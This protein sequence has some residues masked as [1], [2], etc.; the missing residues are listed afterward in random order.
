MR[1]A[2]PALA[3][4]A[5]AVGLALG[6]C[7]L[8]ARLFVAAAPAPA[9]PPPP[10][11]ALRGLPELRSLA[12]LR[13]PGVR[14]VYRGRL[15][16]TNRFGLRGPEISPRPAPG[17]WRIAIVGDSFTL[18]AQVAEKE[19]YAARLE[20]L[21]DAPGAPVEVLNLGLD[22]LD[23]EQIPGR[24]ARVGLPLAP[25]LVVYGFTL[26]DIESPRDPPPP[27]RADAPDPLRFHDSPLY[28][29]RLLGPRLAA[30]AGG[31]YRGYLVGMYEDPEKFARIEAGLDALARLGRSRGVC[32]HVLVHCAVADLFLWH[33]FTEAYQKVEEAARARGMTVTQALPW[34]R[35]K[36][37][38][39]LRVSPLDGHPNAE[40]HRLLA[41]ALA[42]GLRALP[43]RCQRERRAG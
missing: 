21:L 24:L 7:E 25:D 40:G 12:D 15:Y 4:A 17:T 9:P 31:A 11:P 28:L 10:D 27:R 32:V 16:R 43:P 20:A 39:R 35:W 33:P 23:I 34:F 22:G 37:A 2:L 38:A 19:T 41:E 3:L 18:G 29:V 42:D 5:L 8:G 14:G 1:R 6:L 13:R 26:N 36:R 30:L